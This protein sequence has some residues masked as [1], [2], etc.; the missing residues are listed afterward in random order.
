MTTTSV[1]PERDYPVD[2]V[3]L[4]AVDLDGTLLGGV[5]GY[6]IHPAALQA[7]KQARR[8]GIQFAIVTGR[9]YEFIENLVEEYEVL[10]SSVSAIVAEERFI[11]IKDKGLFRPDLE[12]N[13]W[14][15]SLEQSL[16][17]VMQGF[18]VSQWPYLTKLDP[19]VI[20][21]DAEEMRKGWVEL[22]FSTRELAKL[23]VEKMEATIP[24]TLTLIRNV[25]NVGVRGSKI[26]KGPALKQLVE[27]LGLS[28]EN[29]LSIG[30]S[31]NDLSM[32]DTDQFGFQAGTVS[33]ADDEI[34]QF[35]LKNQ[36]WVASKEFGH[37]VA[38]LITN[39]LT[40]RQE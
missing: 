24:P 9:P 27:R 11:Y 1:L 39:V 20:R 17:E 22:V 4:V 33:N 16:L 23:A 5:P 37:G 26:G 32:L 35:V 14:T 7:M 12:Y 29:V 34:K 6:G 21:L 10:E 30:D 40:L 36:G 31:E 38:E 19:D 3:D 13:N 25:R 18:V 28:P 2:W 8:H 15:L